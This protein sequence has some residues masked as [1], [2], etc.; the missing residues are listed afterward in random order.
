MRGLLETEADRRADTLEHVA[1]SVE[2]LGPNDWRCRPWGDDEL[3][4]RVRRLDAFAVM[5]AEGPDAGIA[6]PWKGDFGDALEANAALPGG[7]RI[8]VRARSRRPAARAELVLPEHPDVL[9]HRL[10]RGFLGLRSAIAWLSDGRSKV[11]SVLAEGSC[12][13]EPERLGEL[14]AEAGWPA[15]P[16]DAARWAVPLELDDAFHE[17]IIE[18]ACDGA[19]EAWAALDAAPDEAIARRA[20]EIMLLTAAGRMR[21]ARPVA[22]GQ[23]AARRYGWQVSCPVGFEASDVGHA[24]SA[25]SVACRQTLAEAAALC[26]PDLAQR[27]L[28]LRGWSL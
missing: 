5:A 22:C 16:R 28:R 12:Q 18:A 11:P 9:V 7:A 17:A 2:R 14:C 3:A 8:A 15:T 23:A 19:F 24:L 26:D 1:G 27:Y 13:A 21:L 4:V 20:V 10:S 6:E 25:L